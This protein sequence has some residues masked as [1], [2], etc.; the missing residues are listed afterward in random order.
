MVDNKGLKILL[1]Q[2]YGKSLDSIK[3]DIKRKWDEL[4]ILDDNNYSHVQFPIIL[5]EFI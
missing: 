1:E 3:E 4:G 5:Q 2:K